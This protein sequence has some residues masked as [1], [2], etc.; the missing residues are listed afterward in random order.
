MKYT[1]SIEIDLPREVV[2]L[3]SDPRRCQSGCGAWCCTSR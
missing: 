1:T 2:Q 3:I